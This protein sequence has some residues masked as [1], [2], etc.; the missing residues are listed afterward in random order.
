MSNS[1]NVMISC[2]SKEYSS[3]CAETLEKSGFA[4]T[5]LQPDGE[6]VVKAIKDGM[7]DYAVIDSCICGFDAVS[8]IKQTSESAHFPQFIVSDPIYSELTHKLVVNAGAACYMV[9]PADTHVICDRIRE[10]ARIGNRITAPKN[11]GAKSLETELSNLFR[12]LGIPA[13]V[14]GY[15]YLRSAIIITVKNNDLLNRRVT[16]EL[17]PAVA[18]EFGTTP[19]RV[20]RAMRHAITIAWCRGDIDLIESIFGYTVDQ[21]KGKPTNSEFIA[22]IGD[23]IR[24][25]EL[26]DRLECR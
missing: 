26:N 4:C 23:I 12:R 10:L 22:I 2:N 6:T 13:S 14:S 19:A 18:K 7:Y 20:E 16:K 24:L 5:V 3:R 11:T 8:V 21:N 17:Y 15:A 25:G 1:I 9:Q